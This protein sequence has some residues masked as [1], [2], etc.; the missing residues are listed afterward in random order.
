[1]CARENRRLYGQ[2]P[3]LALIRFTPRLCNARLLLLAPRGLVEHFDV[4]VGFDSFSMWDNGKSY[5]I[6]YQL[7][8]L[9]QI[10]RIFSECLILDAQVITNRLI[11]ISDALIHKHSRGS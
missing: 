3:G 1:M 8:L 4:S 11:S 9:H 5:Q 7:I 6:Q 10:K 2:V